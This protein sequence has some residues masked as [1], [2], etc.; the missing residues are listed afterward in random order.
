MAKL[1]PSILSSLLN[2]RT[3]QEALA[4]ATKSPE[5]LSLNSELTLWNQEQTVVDFTELGVYL[6]LRQALS[7]ARGVASTSVLIQAEI[8]GINL[9]GPGIEFPYS[10]AKDFQPVSSFQ[11][12]GA[13]AT[14]TEREAAMTALSGLLGRLS[15]KS[16]AVA[17]RAVVLF[18]RGDIMRRAQLSPKEITQVRDDYRQ[19]AELFERSGFPLWQARVLNKLGNHCQKEVVGDIAS[20]LRSAIEYHKQ[21]LTL[22]SA[23]EVAVER[24][25]VLHNLGNDFTKLHQHCFTGRDEA[26]RYYREALTYR[27]RERSP[28]IFAE[29][30]H[31]LGRALALPATERILGLDTP[32]RDLLDQAITAYH[33]SLSALQMSAAPALYSALQHDLGVAYFARSQGHGDEGIE[34]LTKAIHAFR[35]A[36]R[37]RNPAADAAEYAT[38]QNA[39]G[40]AYLALPLG[41]QSALR[42]A[43]R[44]FREALRYRSIEREPEYLQIQTTILAWHCSERRPTRRE[45]KQH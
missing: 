22:L 42:E 41:S 37:V 43:E 2:A 21:A 25:D 6:A 20:S 1:D 8:A 34:M 30:M 35:E 9:S 14:P 29:T 19:A 18:T 36:L 33:E 4:A 38:T 26:I 15:K 27:P 40:V 10:L 13:A 39:M 44:C 31:G 16:D 3:P 28:R 7:K 24:G 5:V 32:A 12:R 23:S 45:C 17:V 11:A